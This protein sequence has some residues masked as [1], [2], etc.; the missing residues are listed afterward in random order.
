MSLTEE[1][2]AAPQRRSPRGPGPDARDRWTDFRVG[3][4]ELCRSRP[5]RAGVVLRE[6]GVSRADL[7][8]RDQASGIRVAQR[9]LSRLVERGLLGRVEGGYRTT[10]RGRRAL[11]DLR[12]PD[13][14]DI[15]DV[16]ADPGI[17]SVA[18]ACP[19]GRGRA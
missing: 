3:V 19:R 7:P 8:S 6:L 14:L 15:L 18:R 1:T 17:E 9:N 10:P 13:A 11:D 4:L 16:L 2:A 5:R 12:A